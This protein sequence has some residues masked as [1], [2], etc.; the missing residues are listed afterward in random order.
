MLPNYS[1]VLPPLQTLT[2]AKRRH[3]EEQRTGRTLAGHRQDT[4][5]AGHDNYAGSR[6]IVT[7][8]RISYHP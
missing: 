2:T 5:D 1:N 4:K 3:G 8:S 6:K 7:A